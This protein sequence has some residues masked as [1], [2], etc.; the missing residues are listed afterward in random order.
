MAAAGLLRPVE[1]PV[2]ACVRAGLEMVAASRA[3]AT[4][5]DVRVGVHVG[6]VV[7]GVLGQRQYLFDLF[8]DTVNTAARIESSGVPG[9]VTL[10]AAAWDEVAAGAQADSLGIVEIK[11]KGPLELF[12]FERFLA[13]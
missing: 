10:S 3:L 7:A 9:N 1:A 4:G 2:E 8:G 5:W 6:P 13:G 12:R 11:G